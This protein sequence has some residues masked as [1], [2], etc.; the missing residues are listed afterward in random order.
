MK[1]QPRTRSC[2]PNSAEIFAKKL[3]LRRV[4]HHHH[5]CGSAR[6]AERWGVGGGLLRAACR[7]QPVWTRGAA[8]RHPVHSPAMCAQGSQSMRGACVRACVRACVLRA[9]ER[10]AH[11]GVA[12]GAGTGCAGIRCV[13]GW[14][15][16]RAPR[17][18]QD[19]RRRC[20][21]GAASRAARRGG[22]L[23]SPWRGAAQVQDGG[24]DARQGQHAHIRP[25]AAAGKRLPRA[26]R[27]G[28]VAVACE[29]ARAWL[30][31]CCEHRPRHFRSSR[32]GAWGS[33]LAAFL[34][35]R[36]TPALAPHRTV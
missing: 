22:R 10:T 30:C 36:L 3:K 18:G 35:S 11:G 16:A 12:G 6:A 15:R 27:A 5:G 8:R 17:H 28:A 14:R 1:E 34:L 20:G 24:A 32:A 31:A 2:T 9:C 7:V 13:R 33:S 4:T 29:R 26:V 19:G 25:D 21:G 23:L